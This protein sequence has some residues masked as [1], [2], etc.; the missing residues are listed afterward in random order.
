ME[1]CGRLSAMRL[2]ATAPVIPPPMT[3]TRSAA[4][5]GVVVI[6]NSTIANECFQNQRHHVA[7]DDCS[8]AHHGPLHLSSQ[9][10]KTTLSH[11]TSF[12]LFQLLYVASQFSAMKCM[13]GD[14]SIRTRKRYYVVVI[15]SSIIP[16]SFFEGSPS[17]FTSS[18]AWTRTPHKTLLL[19]PVLKTSQR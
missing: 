6:C 3:A 1:T 17:L 19:N 16:I 10:N 5:F 4:V 11:A 7:G 8:R 14:A 9:I 2:A 18:Q 15:I 13:I 12:Q